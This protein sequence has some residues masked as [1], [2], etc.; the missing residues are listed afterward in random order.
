MSGLQKSLLRR[1]RSASLISSSSRSI[2]RSD[3]D[4]SG[5]SDGDM[6]KTEPVLVESVLEASEGPSCEIDEDVFEDDWASIQYFQF[7]QAQGDP[8][9]AYGREIRID[10]WT[11]PSE[12]KRMCLGFRG[13]WKTTHEVETVRRAIG[14]GLELSFDR[15]QITLKNVSEIKLFVQSRHLN[16]DLGAARDEIVKVPSC[17]E[18]D[19]FS[20]ETLANDAKI[21][22]TSFLD[23]YKLKD[24]CFIRVSFAKGWGTNYKRHSNIKCP[25]WLVIKVTVGLRMLNGSLQSLQP[26]IYSENSS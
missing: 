24:D 5:T 1:K 4:S 26:P 9:V 11:H 6:V 25:C 3:D 7:D 19:I 21:A 14:N 23:T 10:G 8:Y 15:K 18:V 20:L 2:A 13:Y 22:K 17:H 16:R 12:R